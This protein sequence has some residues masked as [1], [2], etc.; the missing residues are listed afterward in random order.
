MDHNIMKKLLLLLGFLLIPST[1]FAQ[2]NG[3]FQPGNVCGNGGASPAVPG[4]T[5]FNTFTITSSLTVTSFDPPSNAI[6]SNNNAVFFNVSSDLANGG[7]GFSGE[8]ASDQIN[9]VYLYGD[10]TSGALNNGKTTVAS[11]ILHFDGGAAGQKF[12]LIIQN[13]C[14]GSGDCQSISIN[15]FY[16]GGYLA[17]GDEGECLYCGQDSEPD[18]KVATISAPP[19][20]G[21]GNTTSTQPIVG[22]TSAQTITVASSAGFANN[23]WVEV[24]I[25]G[26]TNQDLGQREAVQLTGVAAGTLTGIFRL[27]QN[28]G[29]TIAPATVIPVASV[30]GFGNQRWLI[31]TSVSPYTTG[32]IVGPVGNGAQTITGSGT[33]WTNGMVGGNT[34]NPGCISFLQDTTYTSMA[35]GRSIRTWFP[36]KNITSTTAM[37]LTIAR[38]SDIMP[39]G[40]TNTNYAIYPCAQV[41]RV[42]AAGNDYLNGSGSLIIENNTFTWTNGDTI[43]HA[44]GPTLT[45]WGMHTLNQFPLGNSRY[46]GVEIDAFDW[47]PY[48]WIDF[49]PGANSIAATSSGQVTSTLFVGAFANVS[50]APSTI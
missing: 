11:E 6:T 18:N 42:V 20:A 27:N 33:T 48:R 34:Q 36:I 23:E 43:E 29:V 4:P 17:G 7:L 5:P 30:N 31:D 37:S 39:Y 28:T 45:G 44:I 47:I 41:L 19:T 49:V 10:H 38:L 15:N 8:A 26:G 1:A 2:C 9:F 24:N 50:P 14:K 22:S 25:A 46:I 21:G 3:I 12:G 32:L 35:T 13:N 16:T 40:A